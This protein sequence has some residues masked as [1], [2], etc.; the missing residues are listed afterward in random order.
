MPMSMRLD[1]ALTEYRYAKDLTPK[2]Q[3]W[4]ESKLSAFIG[5]CEEQSPSITDVENI[6]APLVRRYLAF[7]RDNPSPRYGRLISSH[8]LHGSARAIK[9][10]LHWAV[11]EDLLSANVPA[12][13]EMP[14]RVQKIVPA[15]T[16][17]Q[18]DALLRAC[19]ESETPDYVARDRAILAVLLDTGIRAAELCTLTLDRVTFGPEEAYLIVNGKGR[20]QREVGLGQ[21]SRQLLHRYI[22]RH[23]SQQAPRAVQTV[24]L[25]KGGTPLTPEGLDRLL[26]RLRDRA[27]LTEQGGD[28]Y[29]LSRLLGHTSVV[30][31]EVY[32]RSFN[33]RAARQGASVFDSL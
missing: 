25:A 29:K 11:R 4:Y 28:L 33:A 7:L 3:T 23:R 10:F 15:L 22:Y 14:R 6:T 13:I 26:Y 32:L 1:A 17:Q 2:S 16:P 21:R 18:I 27:G 19:A 5:W 24:F 30:V 8:T 20:K 9:A 31:T 12:R